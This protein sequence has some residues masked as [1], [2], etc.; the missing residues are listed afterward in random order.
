MI[1]S[2]HTIGMII[3]AI[4]VYWLLNRDWGG[5]NTNNDGEDTETKSDNISSS[6][7][8]DNQAPEPPESKK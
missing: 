7:S 1:M 2:P 4:L 5:D 6:D 3:G 8:E